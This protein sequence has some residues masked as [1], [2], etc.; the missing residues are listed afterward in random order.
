VNEKQAQW[1]IE[2]FTEA[3]RELILPWVGTIVFSWIGVPEKTMDECHEAGEAV[4]IEIQFSKQDPAA[5]LDTSKLLV[6]SYAWDG[7]IFSPHPNMDTLLIMFCSNA[8]PGN[9]YW[10]GSLAGSGDPAAACFSTIAELHNPM[11]NPDY[12]S[13][14]RVLQRRTR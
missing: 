2:V 13:R 9:E 1:Y 6:V 5:K 10:M 11:I 3:I 7:Y 8:F 4:Q 14:I 12:A